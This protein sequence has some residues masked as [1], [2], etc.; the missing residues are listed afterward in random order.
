MIMSGTLRLSNKR[1]GASARAVGRA[2]S[3][4]IL[5]VLPLCALILFFEMTQ[6]AQTASDGFFATQMASTRLDDHSQPSVW[7]GP[8][9]VAHFKG[10]SA[11]LGQAAKVFTASDAER[12]FADASLGIMKVGFETEF[13]TRSR[14]RIWLRILSRDP[15]VDQAI[16]D[17]SRLMDITPASS[18][19]II[20]FAWGRW[21][22]RAQ[23]ED[24]GF[25]PDVVVQK[26]L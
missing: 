7:G 8:S 21:L 24:R 15:I 9:F 1:D 5:T 3:F 20:T 19:N 17:N 14:R 4:A 23:I 10:V 2:V 11:Q 18:A 25:E 12:A 16:P 6:P 22:Y 26:V 13:V